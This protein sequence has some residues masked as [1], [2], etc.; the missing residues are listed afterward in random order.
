MEHQGCISPPLKKLTVPG[1]MF[2]NEVF[3]AEPLDTEFKRRTTNLIIEL[4]GFKEKMKKQLNELK[5][6]DLERIKVM[7]KKTQTYG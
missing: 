5:E 6:K 7:L 4:K 1:E 2:A 3:P